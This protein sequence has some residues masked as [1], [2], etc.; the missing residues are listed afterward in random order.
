MEQWVK[1]RRMAEILVVDDEPSVVAAFTRALEDDHSVVTA[2]TGKQCLKAVAEKPPDCVLLDINMPGMSGMDV[3]RRLAQSDPQ[4]PVIML[5]AVDDVKT[6]VKAMKTGAFDYLTKPCPMDQLKLAVSRAL[7]KRNLELEVLRL[8]AEVGR[9]YGVENIVG[10]HAS[11]GELFEKVH[12]VA[13][14]RSTVLVTGESGTG[15][16]LVARAI[17]QL[18]LGPDKPFVPMNCAAIP[19][20]LVEA[21]FFGHERG[22]FTDAHTTRVGQFEKAHGGTLFLDEVSELSPSGQAKLLRVLQEKEFARVGGQRPI[23][24]DVRL[25]AATNKDLETEVEKGEFRQDLFYRIHVVPIR[26]PPLRQRRSDI[27]LLAAHFL[28]RIAERDSEPAKRVSAES[29]KLLTDHEWPGNV[30]ELENVCEQLSAL[31]GEEE[32]QADVVASTLAVRPSPGF[33]AINAVLGGEITLVEAV[34]R[35]E[36]EAIDRALD[37]CGGSQT[38]AAEMLGISRRILGYKLS[39]AREEA[40]A[41]GDRGPSENSGPEDRQ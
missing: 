26:L 37:R 24:V 12:M 21:E 9:A 5:T 15:K 40:A 30:R 18:G 29:L 13:P 16:E 36:M 1:A 27:P 11:M 2:G 39:Q 6:A 23:K 20:G 32:I 38:K 17:H 7:E 34:R 25:I 8:R 3:L 10:K 33:P 19:D 22:A 31:A 14:R 35:F 41:R 28:G 4:V